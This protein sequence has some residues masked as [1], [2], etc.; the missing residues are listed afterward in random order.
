MKERKAAGGEGTTVVMV[1]FTPDNPGD[2]C[3]SF[4]QE[5]FSAEEWAAWSTSR[6]K[7]GR[8][9]MAKRGTLRCHLGNTN[10]DRG[11]RLLPRHVDA[12]FDMVGDIID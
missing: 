12:V 5:V 1:Y 7:D 3:L 9:L 4:E 11:Y 6:R 8:L 2:P 10:D